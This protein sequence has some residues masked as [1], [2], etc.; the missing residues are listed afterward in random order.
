MEHIEMVEKLREK[1]NVSYE[2]ARAA[3][4]Q[5]D[6]DLLDALVALESQGKI[7]R[8]P[9]ESFTTKKEPQPVKEHEQDLRGIFA[10]F[11]A[12]IVELINKGN[13]STLDIK[14]K[15]KPVIA[16]PLTIV[17][18]LMILIFWVVLWLLVVGF[19]FGFRYSISGPL[20][21][22]PVNKAMDK[23]AQ[24]AEGIKSSLNQDSKPDQG[25]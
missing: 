25:A 16:I 11:F 23:A 13:K 15:G 9:Q 6:W 18:V 1:A 21:S 10:R 20:G 3:L 7:N 19:F 14:R 12:Y 4:E 5:N 22:E 8:E 17:A 24:A 2:E